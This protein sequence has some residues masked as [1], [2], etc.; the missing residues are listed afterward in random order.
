[1]RARAAATVR[2]CVRASVRVCIPTYGC[3]SMRV[4]A[5][6]RACKCVRRCVCARA[7]ATVTVCGQCGVVSRWCACAR[8][9][10]HSCMRMRAHACAD[11]IRVRQVC[12]NTVCMARGPGS[13]LQARS[14]TP[15]AN[16]GVSVC[17]RSWRA[18]VRTCVSKQHMLSNSNTGPRPASGVE[19]WHVKCH[20]WHATGS[21]RY[22]RINTSTGSN[23]QSMILVREDER[24]HVILRK[25]HGIQSYPHM[26]MS[27]SHRRRPVQLVRVRAPA[28]AC[29]CARG[30]T[31][32][33]ESVTA[34]VR[35]HIFAS[36]EPRTED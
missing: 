7:T 35:A 2:V 18:R 4:R 5:F 34:R 27:V 20:H 25:T 28:A 15:H 30:H 31:M 3:L 33:R 9:C 17:A 1:M 10:V 22:V 29:M 11:V 32:M 14:C 16:H 24:Q 36:M 8:A 21:V 13:T 19:H 26:G 12:A 6:L 23:P